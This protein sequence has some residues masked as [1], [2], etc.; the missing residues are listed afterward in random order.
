MGVILGTGTNACYV[1]NVSNIKKWRGPAPAREHMIIN[2]EW[3]NFNRLPLT[4]CD[5]ELDAASDRPGEQIL[6]K[7]VSGMYLGEV[8]RLALKRELGREVMGRGVLTSEHVSAIVGDRTPGLLKAGKIFSGLGAG[9]MPVKDISA[10]KRVCAAVST[11]A[12]R[13]S[14]AAMAAVLTKTDPSLRDRHTVAIDGSVYEKHPD[15]SKNMKTALR[16]IFGKGASNIKMVLA[17]D[18]SGKGAAIIA[19][20]AAGE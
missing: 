16:E 13:I 19:A 4:Q 9:K 17:K 8:V 20:I 14:A 12:A 6:E 18:G 2:I 5:K 7:M 11:R 3:G 1:E 10:A 15:F